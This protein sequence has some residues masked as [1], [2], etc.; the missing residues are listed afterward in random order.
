MGNEEPKFIIKT[1]EDSVFPSDSATQEIFF[2]A[3]YANKNDLPT[4]N[5]VT[6]EDILVT[7]AITDYYQD[8]PNDEA[9]HVDSGLVNLLSGDDIY[10]PEMRHL[11]I[12]RESLWFTALSDNIFFDTD[13][14]YSS[15]EI[16]HLKDQNLFYDDSP[17]NSVIFVGEGN[18]DLRIA[19]KQA[20]I[21][22][23]LG[24]EAAIKG[25]NSSINL[26]TTLD[27]TS[28]LTLE[29]EFSNL[30]LNVYSHEEIAIDDMRI[31]DNQ[32]LFG[33]EN[34]PYIDLSNIRYSAETIEIK[35]YNDTGLVDSQ[36]LDYS[37]EIMEPTAQA[38]DAPPELDI[39]DF[40]HEDDIVFDIQTENLFEKDVEVINL[41]SEASSFDITDV[42]NELIDRQTNNDDFN[43][44][45]EKE[46]GT[47][48]NEPET[49]LEAGQ[50][51]ADPL[52]IFDENDFS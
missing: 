15:H 8:N 2:D 22:M 20:D 52:D 3:N 32:L 47:L 33:G 27:Q 44:N 39:T 14:V 41:H 36:I 45:V 19:E 28:A 7:K 40:L 30:S 37:T 16:I 29:G 21:F 18:S 26:F 24:T 1:E 38:T 5:L 11:D 42:A 13:L 17:H 43:I 49:L 23:E 12:D 9:Y 48:I 46:L 25:E 10:G 34:S 4:T 35:S 51:F 6:E 50:L 31:V